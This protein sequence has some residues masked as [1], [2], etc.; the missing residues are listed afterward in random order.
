M[1]ADELLKVIRW[2][3]QTKRPLLVQLPEREYR[4]VRELWGLP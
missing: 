4:R 3:D 1:P 2:L